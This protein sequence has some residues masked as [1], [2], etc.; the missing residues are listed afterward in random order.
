MNALLDAGDFFCLLMAGVPLN[1]AC[2]CASFS[3]RA[4]YTV[5]SV[6]TCPVDY[7]VHGPHSLCLRLP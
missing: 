1:G 2:P 3:L 6:S 5:S 4:A 7:F